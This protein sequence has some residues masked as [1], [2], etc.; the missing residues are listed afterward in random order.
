MAGT[1]L[2]LVVTVSPGGYSFDPAG[3]IYTDPERGI[4]HGAQ[5]WRRTQAASPWVEGRTLVNAVQDV[6]VG[7]L[8]FRVFGTLAEQKT[9]T[10]SLITAFSQVDYTTTITID[11][12]AHVWS[13][14][15]PA[16]Y[17][18]GSSSGALSGPHMMAGQQNIVFQIPHAPG[19]T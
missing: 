6:A 3:G 12:T 10:V 1:T 8:T 5:S 19:V 4:S 2:T 16:D 17:T 11:G 7:I 14:C 15:E 18:I 13:N 9:R